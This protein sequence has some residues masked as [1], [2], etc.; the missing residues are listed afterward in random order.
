MRVRRSVHIRLA[1]GR[2]SRRSPSGRRA[3]P[4]TAL[5]RRKRAGIVAVAGALLLL[6]WLVSPPSSPPLWDGLQLPQETYRY[7]HPPAG[8]PKGKAPTTTRASIPL[9]H[10]RSQAVTISTSERPPQANLYLD[11]NAIDIP[12]GVTHVT[13]IIQPVDPPA[14]VSGGTIDGNVYLFRVTGN[15]GKVLG[16]RTG[17]RVTI[18]LRST[19]QAGTRKIEQYVGGHWVPHGTVQ[20]LTPHIYFASAPSLGPFAIV[21][22]GKVTAGSWSR[23]ILPF[24]LIGVLVV[25]IVAA[26]LLLVRLNRSR[27][28][29]SDST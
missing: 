5:R 23:S 9:S 27:A 18:A 10:G 29:E 1:E 7:L 3:D 19:R 24:I 13:A 8:T 11:D 22:V 28:A 20:S 14:P 25:G 26:L 4:G 6:M 21:L 12:S 15:G 16:V 17:A 2:L